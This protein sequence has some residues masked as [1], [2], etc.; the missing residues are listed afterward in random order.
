MPKTG[1][2]TG[3][4]GKFTASFHREQSISG[5]GTAE[6]RHRRAAAA[7]TFPAF[8]SFPAFTNRNT[9]N[10]IRPYERDKAMNRQERR[11]TAAKARRNRF[12]EDYV[13]HLP[14]VTD[15]DLGESGVRHVVLY[16]DDNC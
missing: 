9:S 15:E 11:R 10:H 2:K 16:H 3:K 5:V 12:V 4:T 7:K 6:L 8:P 14:E 1:G 13:E